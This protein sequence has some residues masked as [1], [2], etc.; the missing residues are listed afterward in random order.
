MSEF[1]FI[2]FVG[3]S[4]SWQALMS[5]GSIFPSQFLPLKYY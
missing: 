3:I 5:Q 1:D 2:T 4:E